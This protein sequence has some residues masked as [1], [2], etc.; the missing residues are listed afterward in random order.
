MINFP[1][2]S[3]DI[4]RVHKDQCIEI[5]DL[6]WI[7]PCLSERRIRLTIEDNT[8]KHLTSS[9]PWLPKG[10]MIA[11]N[12]GKVCEERE[13]ARAPHIVHLLFSWKQSAVEGQRSFGH[14]DALL[15]R[16]EEGQVLYY[17]P[18][19]APCKHAFELSPSKHGFG[20][21]WAPS[22]VRLQ[23][24]SPLPSFSCAC[25][26]ALFHIPNRVIWQTCVTL[27]QYLQDF[28]TWNAQDKFSRSFGF[29][30]SRTGD[31]RTYSEKPR[32][33]IKR[34]QYTMFV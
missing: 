2:L 33:A 21:M 31:W 6:R 3:E 10:C 12:V 28:F 18:P 11:A 23:F 20:F 30:Q 9:H 29:L 14:F 13:E 17:L 22:R 16:T 4:L 32:G 1:D 27:P 5:P 34:L 15:P 19:N 26:T 24:Q 25:R 8:Y 7:V